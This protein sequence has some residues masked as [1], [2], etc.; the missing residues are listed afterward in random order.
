MSLKVVLVFAIAELFLSLTPGPAVLLVVGQGMKHNFVSSIRGTLGILCGNTIYFALSA[1]GLGAVLLASARLFTAIKWAGAVYLIYLGVKMLFAKAEEETDG[2]GNSIAPKRSLKL[3]VQG[4][5]T[6]LSNPKAI[7]F[8]TAL[9]P[10]F[11]APE[12]NVFQQF[13]VLGIVSI[14]VEFP[15]LLA[16]GWLAERGKRLLPRGRFSTLPD[17]IGGAF[18]VGTGIALALKKAD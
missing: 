15:V 18:L 14:S 11:V 2:P 7:V 9:L 6:Q 10:Q 13:L 17:R 4:L 3:F 8:F 16:Y 1:L 12:G 5:I